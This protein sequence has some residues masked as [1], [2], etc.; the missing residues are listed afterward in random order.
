MED[1]IKEEFLNSIRKKSEQMYQESMQRIEAEFSQRLPD[2][3][4]SLLEV[5]VQTLKLYHALL[6]E[7]KVGEL[8]FIYFSFLRTG[9]IFDSPNYRLDFYDSKNRASLVECAGMWDFSCIFNYLREIKQE[10]SLIFERQTR[11]PGWEL[12]NT[13]HNLANFYRAEADK[14]IEDVLYSVLEQNGTQLIG[15]SSVKF[16]IGELYDRANLILQWDEGTISCP[17]RQNGGESN[18]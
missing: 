16:F 5:F 4:A 3:A 9:I 17:G 11:V 12:D 18:G 10:L 8:K 13:L 2:I 14:K 15:D 1:K 6:A 7:G